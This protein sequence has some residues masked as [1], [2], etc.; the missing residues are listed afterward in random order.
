[1]ELSNEQVF[2]PAKPFPRPLFPTT[3]NSRKLCKKIINQSKLTDVQIVTEEAIHLQVSWQ[4]GLWNRNVIAS[5]FKFP[6]PPGGLVHILDIAK[7]YHS[8]QSIGLFLIAD[9][10][11]VQ[12]SPPWSYDQSYQYLGSIATPSVHPAT[13]ISPGRASGMTSLTAELSSRLSG[14]PLQMVSAGMP[15][16]WSL[17]PQ[18]LLLQLFPAAGEACSEPSAESHLYWLTGICAKSE[19]IR[20]G[21]Q[22]NVLK[23]ERNRRKWLLWWCLELQK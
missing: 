1:M 12:P 4:R 22:H 16:R 18:V 7:F 2:H 9:T 6:R 20:F 17:C 11:Q 21:S 5:P 19:E 8:N 23:R 3:W 14:E 15:M 10:R 13:P